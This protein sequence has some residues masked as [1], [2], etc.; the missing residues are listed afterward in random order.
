MGVLAVLGLD[1][2]EAVAPQLPAVD[3]EEMREITGSDYFRG[4]LYTPGA[5]LI[6]PAQVHHE[7]RGITREGCA[8]ARR[9]RAGTDRPTTRRPACPL[10]SSS[11]PAHVI[12]KPTN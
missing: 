8:R 1:H 7:R 11:A 6:E 12:S 3:A 2:L 5:V 9:R 4:G 10:T